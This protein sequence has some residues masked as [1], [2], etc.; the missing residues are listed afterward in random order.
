MID[1]KLDGWV[2]TISNGVRLV[3]RVAG[4]I[5]NDEPFT[6]GPVYELAPKGLLAAT[7]PSLPP[8]LY[9]NGF[10]VVAALGY[11]SIERVTI[12]PGAIVVPCFEMSEADRANLASA[13]DGWEA[14]RR[15]A[16]SNIMVA[17]PSAFEG[18]LPLPPRRS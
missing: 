17:P 13:I 9:A 6:L 2:I 14:M 8:S 4:V 5:K 1:K 7:S 10:S 16:R 3:G 11:D 15:Q 12:P 18:R